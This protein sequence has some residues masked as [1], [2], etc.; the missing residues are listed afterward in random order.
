MKL[1]TF[2]EI[3]DSLIDNKHTVEHFQ[4]G[5]S[6]DA[7]VAILDINTIFDFEENKTNACADKYVSI[8]ILEDESDY[9]AFKNFG[10]DSWVKMD[11]FSDINGLLN[12]IEKREFS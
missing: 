3:Q 8:A 2:C 7:Q 11:N 5:S 12:L 6:G 10:I 1:V 4:S 9:E